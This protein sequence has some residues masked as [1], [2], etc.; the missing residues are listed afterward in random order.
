MSEIEKGPGGM[1]LSDA[2]LS[3]LNEQ[4]LIQLLQNVRERRA[5]ASG[6]RRAAPHQKGKRKRGPEV[7]ELDD[8]LGGMLDEILGG[9]EG[10]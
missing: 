8:V 2:I 10:G 1:L 5:K 9:Q 7:P 4:E 3:E 6:R